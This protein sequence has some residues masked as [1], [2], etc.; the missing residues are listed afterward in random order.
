MC[1]FYIPIYPIKWYMVFSFGLISG[2]KRADT[3]KVE[4]YI[5]SGYI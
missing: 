3:R 5:K 4:K 1:Y 2:R